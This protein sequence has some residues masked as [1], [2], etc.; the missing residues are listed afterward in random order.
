MTLTSAASAAGVLHFP[1]FFGGTYS[2]YGGANKSMPCSTIFSKKA[3][4]FVPKEYDIRGTKGEHA[5]LSR[6]LKDTGPQQGSRGEPPH[7]SS[8]NVTLPDRSV[9]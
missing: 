6:P 3:L 7:G 9:T 5:N 4:V 1:F 8:F 2:V